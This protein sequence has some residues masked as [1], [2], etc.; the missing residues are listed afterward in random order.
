M[1]LFVLLPWVSAFLAFRRAFSDWR[2][3]A[4]AASV[5]WGALVVGLTEGLSLFQALSFLPLLVAWGLLSCLSIAVCMHFWHPYAFPKGTAAKLLHETTTAD[6]LLILGTCTILLVTLLVAL[7]APP[8]TW[9]SMTYHMARVAN[10]IDHRSVRDYPTHIIRQ[11]YLGPW[12]EFAITHLQILS[13]GDHFANLVQFFAMLGSVLGVSLLAKKLGAASRGQ[14]FAA[15]FCATIPMGILQASSTQTDYVTAFWFVA[16]LNFATDLMDS[17]APALKCLAILAGASLGLAALTKM[18]AALFVAPFLLWLVF[19]LGRKQRAKAVL[20]VGALV[21]TAL[22]INAGHILRNQFAF[23][24]PLGPRAEVA[25]Y[26]NEIHTPAALA[27]NLIRNVA[28][29]LGTPQGTNSALGQGI[30]ATV[31]RAESLTGL[32]I[33]DR[34]TT[35]LD[36]QFQY[37]LSF[38]EDYAGNPLHMILGVFALLVALWGFRQNHNAAVYS[39]CLMVAFLLF[40]GYLKWRPWI[41]R[42]QL[43]M[44]VAVAPL[45]GLLLGREVLRRVAPLFAALLIVLGFAYATQGQVRPLIGHASILGKPRTDLYFTVRS[46]LRDPFIAAASEIARGGPSTVGIISGLDDWEYPLRLLVRMHSGNDVKFEHF[47]V[48]NPSQNCPPDLP[49]D[50]GLPQKIVVIGAFRSQDLP[51]GYRAAYVSDAIRVF[52]HVPDAPRDLSFRLQDHH[53][54]TQDHI[55]WAAAISFDEDM[56][57]LYVPGRWHAPSGLRTQ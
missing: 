51:A 12:A 33:N 28:V 45:A 53:E 6:G 40:C 9:D 34:R 54:A 10:W 11:L 13:G 31:M 30:R 47:R 14:L 52:E 8:N 46:A 15:V 43:P 36:T 20:L 55:G 26:T 18:T 19:E 39:S 16:F 24:W 57:N 35:F 44:F 29:H 48:Q 49:E 4:L 38:N 42:L 23:G 56:K 2:Q 7:V 5:C 21:M 32:N 50:H 37:S 17:N 41:S 25:I 1:P 22:A 27:S 3:A